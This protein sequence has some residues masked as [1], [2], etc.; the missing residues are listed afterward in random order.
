MIKLSIVIITLNEE[1]SIERCI[2]SVKTIADEIVVL[3]SYSTD[4][5][6]FICKR[7]G[8]KFYQNNF[9]GYRDQKNN[10]INLASYDH[11][12]SLDADEALS[13]ELIDS[14]KKIK[15]NWSYDAYYCKRLNNYCGQW[16]HYSNWYPDKKIR[17]FDRRKGKWGGYNLHETIHMDESSR[18]SCLDGDLLH[19]VYSSYD[20][21]VDKVNKYSTIGAI[22]YFNAGKRASVLSPFLHML[23]RFVKSYFLYCG[24]LDGFNGFVICSISSYSSF[25][26]YVKL[27]R[28]VIDSRNENN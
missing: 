14:I 8:V 21:H 18:V 15:E 20:E 13:Q 12:L 1:E 7:L 28:L 23:W 17:L 25:L 3:D 6:E 27:R 24:F 10:A 2:N 11:I 4:Q 9:T 16:I 22:E 5:T 26:K 19:W